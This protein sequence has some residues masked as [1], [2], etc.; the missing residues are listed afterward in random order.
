M[1]TFPRLA[2]L[3]LLAATPVF[4]AKLDGIYSG[5]GGLTPELHRVVLIVFADDGTALVQQNWD[6]KPDPE[7][8]HA[9]WTKQDDKVVLTFDPSAPGKPA[10]KPLHLTLKRNTLTATDWDGQALGVLGPPQ[11]RPFGGDLPHRA[12]VNGCVS[13]NSRD[14]SQN[15]VNW[16][17]KATFGD[18]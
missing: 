17:S 12:T 10:L 16:G 8:W 5:S 7:V 2:A 6:N 4:A 9:R 15:C 13:V 14:P 1:R 3:L 11:L 18:H